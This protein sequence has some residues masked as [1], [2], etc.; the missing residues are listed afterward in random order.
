MYQD[1]AILALSGPAVTVW[2]HQSPRSYTHCTA[3][4][5]R[6]SR[7]RTIGPGGI[8]RHEFR[9]NIGKSRIP[10]MPGILG[11]LSGFWAFPEHNNLN[12]EY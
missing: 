1:V 9:H 5:A 10:G 7:S 2:L 11:I 3:S 8:C 12:L 4:P 6:C